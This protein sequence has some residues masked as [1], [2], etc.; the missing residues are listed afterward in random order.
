MID[1]DNDERLDGKPRWEG[2]FKEAGEKLDYLAGGGS[3]AEWQAFCLAMRVVA[4]RRAGRVN[5][6][7][8]RALLKR[9]GINPN[10]IG[11]FYR[12]ALLAGLLSITPELYDKS[13][14]L[15]SRNRGK[16]I[17]VYT[18]QPDRGAES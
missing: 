6:N 13:R 15:H 5:P 2:V 11:S 3:D 10:R 9:A 1:Q 7:A 8:M 18:Y 17:R 4:E 16:P 12:K 14:D